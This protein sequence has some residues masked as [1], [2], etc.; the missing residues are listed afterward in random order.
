M[1][2]V[3]LG[4]TGISPSRCL[5]YP[6]S[7]TLTMI[8]TLSI[9]C[10]LV[11]TPLIIQRRECRAPRTAGGSAGGAARRPAPVESVV[12]LHTR[13][14]LMLTSQDGASITDKMLIVRYSISSIT[15]CQARWSV[16]NI[17]I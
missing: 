10:L 9:A 6:L 1:V 14:S 7:D 2:P 16:Q 5:D 13:P 11:E 4:V 8:H 12:D 15:G 3:K 17:G